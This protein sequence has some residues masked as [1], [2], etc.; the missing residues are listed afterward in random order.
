MIVVVHLK[1]QRLCKFFKLQVVI[2]F[3]YIAS[4]TT[5]NAYLC[6]NEIL[7]K[8]KMALKFCPGI[9]PLRFQCLTL[10]IK[11]EPPEG[12]ENQKTLE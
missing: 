2:A 9:Y 4:N 1:F 11:K 7:F 5:R 8:E 10:P 12:G 3:L 6:N